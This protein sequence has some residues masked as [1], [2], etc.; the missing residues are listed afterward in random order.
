MSVLVSRET[1]VIFQGMTGAQGTFFADQAMAYGT[2]VVAGVTPAGGNE[3]DPVSDAA[4]AIR[5]VKPLTVALDR[6]AERIDGVG[7]LDLKQRAGGSSLVPASGGSIRIVSGP[8][9]PDGLAPKLQAMSP[10]LLLPGV[11]EFARDRV[12][13]LEI[14]EGFV[15]ALLVGAN[16]EWA[17]EALWREFPA[18][19]DATAFASLFDR[20]GD[21]PA[22]GPDTD[23]NAE[24]AG[25]PLEQRL[26]DM[27]G[28]SGTGTVLLM[29]AELVRRFPGLVVSLL[30]PSN[31]GVPMSAT[32]ELMAEHVIAPMFL[33]HIDPSTIFVGF[34]VDPSVVL[35]EEWYLSVEEPPSGPRF[36][37]DAGG[38]SG[39]DVHD[40]GPQDA[41]E[42]WADL[43]W[44]HL[45][46]AD[47]SAT[48]IR[49]S[50]V[51]WNGTERAGVEWGRNGAHQARLAFQQPY[52][53]I[54]P[55]HA[56]IGARR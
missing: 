42:S 55:A 5:S 15:A 28:G 20:P 14:N 36:G 25:V 23:L 7:R 22:P 35:G 8:W 45:R 44:A 40:G 26:S 41:P 46:S 13:L 38:G 56:L 32:G 9:F 53:M 30:R 1:K 19:L 37:F 3:S 21:P 33:G 17:R 31:G 11:G 48:H 4:V 6:L 52:R 24:L 18:D 43:T 49:L 54:F 12:R 16:H 34:D 27:V 47:P 10:E 2:R 50:A 51:G 39:I 29:R